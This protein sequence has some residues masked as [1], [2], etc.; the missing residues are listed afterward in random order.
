MAAGIGDAHLFA[1]YGARLRI[2][3]PIYDADGDLVTGAATLDSEIS[4]DF[5]T[6]ID[7]ANEAIEISTSGLYYLDLTGT[8]MEA[9]F[10]SGVTKTSTAGA[11]TAIW[12]I[13]ILR[14]APILTGTLQAGSLNTVT[15]QVSGSPTIND[16][17]NGCI[18][19]PTNDTP[20]NVKGQARTIIDFNGSTLVATMD[21]DFGTNPSSSTTYEIYANPLLT[22]NI[23]GMGESILNIPA[24]GIIGVD[25]IRGSGSAT[26]MDNLEAAFATGLAEPSAIFSWP[27]TLQDLLKWMG[28]VAR[29][30]VTQTNTTQ[31]VRNTADSADIGS[32]TVSDDGTTFIRGA[33]I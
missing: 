12:N 30:K 22:Q 29:N 21:K 16:V 31:K 19:K 6:P 26:L 1:F 4:K 33:F 20:T 17:L 13:P 32:S 2:A 28:A 23:I 5:G 9:K 11:K 25:A 8:E 10:V 24:A 7:C 27:A 14:P 15:L 3:F 18:F